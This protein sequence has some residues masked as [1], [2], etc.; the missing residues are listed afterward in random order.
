MKIEK[1]V[2][3]VWVDDIRPKPVDYDVALHSVNDVIVYLNVIRSN[4]VSI[5]LDLDH[6]AGDF[7]SDGGDY[8]R[9][10]DWIEETKFISA[11]PDIHLMFRIH[12]ANLVGRE[13]MRCII[14]KNGWPLLP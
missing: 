4:A 6:D 8:V 3:K 10:L 13:N 9:I 7:I 1:K 14:E 12:S 2:V 11:N 5:L